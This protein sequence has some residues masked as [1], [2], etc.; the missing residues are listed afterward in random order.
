MPVDQQDRLVTKVRG[1]ISVFSPTA[2]EG[3]SRVPVHSLALL[4]E[5]LPKK[6]QSRRNNQI[7]HAEKQQI[8]VVC[9]HYIYYTHLSIYLSEYHKISTFGPLYKDEFETGNKA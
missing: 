4:T 5:E 6:E 1:L 3:S 9:G 7:S 2:A 8:Y